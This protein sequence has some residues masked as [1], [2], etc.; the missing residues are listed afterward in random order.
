MLKSV[1]AKLSSVASSYTRFEELD[2]YEVIVGYS[3]VP[4]AAIIDLFGNIMI[5]MTSALWDL[6]EDARLAALYHELGHLKHVDQNRAA[7]ARAC[8]A[9]C[10]IFDHLS[11]FELVDAIKTLVGVVSNGDAPV[12]GDVCLEVEADEYAVQAGHVDGLIRILQNKKL[13]NSLSRRQRRDIAFRVSILLRRKNV[14]S[15]GD[16]SCLSTFLS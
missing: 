8:D 13:L 12:A 14:S 2:G 11:N 9:V 5:Y 6:G 16:W 3:R 7:V 10:D 15:R 4:N 1:V